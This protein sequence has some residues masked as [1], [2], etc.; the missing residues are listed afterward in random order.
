MTGN[1]DINGNFFLRYGM[2]KSKIVFFVILPF[3]FFSCDSHDSQVA[4]TNDAKTPVINAVSCEYLDVKTAVESVTDSMIVNIPAGDC[5]WGTNTLS[6]PG[7]VHLCGAGNNQTIIRR[8]GNT[9]NFLIVFNGEIGKPVS[10]SG[11]TLMGNGDAEIDDGGLIIKDSQD[12]KVWGSEFSD[13]NAAAISVSYQNSQNLPQRGLI[14]KNS[15]FNNFRHDSDRTVQMG[16]GVVVYGNGTWPD[17]DLGSQNAVFI[18]DN[19]FYGNRHDIASNNG[20]VYVFRYNTIVCT[21]VGM[22]YAKTDAHGLSSSERGSRSYEIYNNVYTTEFSGNGMQRAAIGIRGG[23]GV[24]FNN[25]VHGWFS[26]VVELSV[27]YPAKTQSEISQMEHPVQDQIQ[28]LYV[29]NNYASQSNPDG[30][31][32]NCPVLLVQDREYFLEAKP[33]YTPYVYPHPLRGVQ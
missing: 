25:S 12:F 31:A 32:N 10:F 21:D 2:F 17:L 11:I 19:Y 9:S 14:F 15:F 8:V 16:Y 29:W 28:S 1:T 4:V 26:S 13:F 33:G 3:L 5:N 20:S 7:G 18:E 23:D 27:E 24:I 6:V 30:I 22:D